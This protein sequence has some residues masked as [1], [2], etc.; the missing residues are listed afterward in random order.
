MT[1]KS[2]A[3]VTG[4]AG[5]IGSHLVERLLADGHRVRVF[6]NF[7]TGSRANLDF[8]RGERLLQVVRGDLVNLAA[9]KRA[10]AGVSVIFNQAALRSVP[11]SLSHP[12][13]GPRLPPPPPRRGRTAQKP[14]PGLRLLLVRVRRAPGPAEARGSADGSDLPVCGHQGRGG[15]LRGR[16]EPPLRR[17]DGGPALLQRVRPPPG[18][19]ERVRRGDPALHSL[20]DARP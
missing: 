2:L 16:V 8:A 19:Q 10:V 11:R 7:S 3:L 6:D 1:T 14:A 18:P 12:L 20:G 4:G 5:F 9:V 13:Q 15:G 17:G